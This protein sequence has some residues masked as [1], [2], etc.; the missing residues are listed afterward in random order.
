MKIINGKFPQAVD[1]GRVLQAGG[2]KPL[3]NKVFHE[4]LTA[5]FANYNV[6]VT[7]Y[8]YRSIAEQAKLY[9]DYKNDPAHNNPAAYPGTSWHNCALAFDVN[10]QGTDP[11]GTG[12]WPATMEADFLLPPT[13]QAMNKWGLCIPM[14]KG[15]KTQ[16]NWHIQPIEALNQLVPQWFADDD[17]LLNNTPGYRQ[18]SLVAIP[19]WT[20]D[21][22]YMEGKDVQ[23]S[24]RAFGMTEYGVCDASWLSAC[25]AYQA[26]NG[27][28]ADGYCGPNTWAKI[29]AQLGPAGNNNCQ[30][31]IDE[32]NKQ[33]DALNAQI[34][35]LNQQLAAANA[36]IA[37]LTKQLSD[38]QA[39]V[40]ALKVEVATLTKELENTK[41][42]LAAVTADR[43]NKLK[44]L[45]TLATCEKTKNAI[46]SKY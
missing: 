36:N 31:E 10:S 20:G 19:G 13:Q 37:Y 5:Y 35:S 24:M 41:A 38:T 15:A 30:E 33:I 16:E 2:T 45:T 22:V 12:H 34:A 28:T 26:K 17:D 40:N 29:N 23:R 1:D 43:D 7:G 32:L 14:W 6:K 42:T 39:Q 44:E 21:P 9:L 18:L 4:R 11:D 25:K 46:L 27:L 3:L 8:G